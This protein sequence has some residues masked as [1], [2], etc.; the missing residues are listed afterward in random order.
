MS[1][2]GFLVIFICTFKYEQVRLKRAVSLEPS[3]LGIRDKYE[4]KVKW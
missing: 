1:L 3:L 2:S 4:S